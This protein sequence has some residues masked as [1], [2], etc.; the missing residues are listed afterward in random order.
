MPFALRT[1]PPWRRHALARRICPRRCHVQRGRPEAAR[2]SIPVF[3][4]Y[5]SP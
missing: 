3:S 2:A 5:P 1:G 4:M